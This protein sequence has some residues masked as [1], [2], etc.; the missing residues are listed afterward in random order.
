MGTEPRYSERPDRRLQP[1]HPLGLHA[2][3]WGGHFWSPSS[4]AASC[5]GAPPSI[6]EEYIENQKRPGRAAHVNQLSRH[7]S[8]PEALPRCRFLPGVNARGSTPDHAE[9]HHG[10]EPSR[11]GPVRLRGRGAGGVVRRAAAAVRGGGLA[12]DR[13]DRPPARSRAPA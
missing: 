6:T 12:A 7:R 9:L 8:G 11:G 10:H 2:H 1:S 3:L 13:R 5:G 4:F